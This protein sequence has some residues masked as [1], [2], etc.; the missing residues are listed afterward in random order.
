M[1]IKTEKY[2][3][4]ASDGAYYNEI[5]AHG[6]SVTIGSPDEEPVDIPI[7]NLAEVV[8]V[9]QGIMEKNDIPIV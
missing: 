1:I 2:T 3:V 5:E 9:L 8:H 4:C 6:D 7:E